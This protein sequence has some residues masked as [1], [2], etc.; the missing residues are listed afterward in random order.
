M[1]TTILGSILVGSIDPDRLSRA[2]RELVWG[3]RVAGSS[4]VSPEF[5][6]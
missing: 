1:A 5:H 4:P 2:V 3:T 6:Q